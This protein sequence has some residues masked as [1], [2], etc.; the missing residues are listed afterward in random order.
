VCAARPRDS[1]TRATETDETGAPAYADLAPSDVDVDGAPVDER[2]GAMVRLA[3][4][5][6]MTPRASA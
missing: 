5:A 1:P 6:Y 2:A 4:E 3:K